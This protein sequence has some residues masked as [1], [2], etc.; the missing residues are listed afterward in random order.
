MLDKAIE[1]NKEFRKPYRG[2]KAVDCSC[3]NNGDCPYCYSNRM[4]KNIKEIEKI[5]LDGYTL[6]KEL[7]NAK[8]LIFS[9]KNF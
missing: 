9:R 4:Y 8:N 3:R 5:N 7:S 1:H 2:A 6:N